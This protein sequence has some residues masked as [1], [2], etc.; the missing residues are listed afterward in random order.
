MK[1]LADREPRRRSADELAGLLLAFFERRRYPEK[2]RLG[3]SLFESR[4]DPVERRWLDPSP[5]SHEDDTEVELRGPEF[6]H[7]LVETRI[8]EQGVVC[9]AAKQKVALAV[10]LLPG[11]APLRDRRFSQRRERKV[12]ALEVREKSPHGSRDGEARILQQ[13][14]HP[15][16]DDELDVGG[17]VEGVHVLVGAVIALCAGQVSALEVHLFEEIVNVI[18][19]GF[20][21]E[22]GDALQKHLREL[23]D[24]AAPG[25]GRDREKDEHLDETQRRLSIFGL[26]EQTRELL[27]VESEHHG[28]VGARLEGFFYANPEMVEDRIGA[29]KRLGWGV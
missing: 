26:G 15:S 21:F 5:W 14:F 3:C 4:E 11:D 2:K 13:S 19:V 22:R 8:G 25:D 29:E 12:G 27:L 28:D 17:E 24:G 20:G 18:V 16:L 6:F 1:V 23:G 10:G 7:Q 9:V